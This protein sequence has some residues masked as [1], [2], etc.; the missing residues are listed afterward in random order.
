MTSC[1]SF[2]CPFLPLFNNLSQ[3]LF[4]IAREQQP[5]V[6]FFDE[7]DA[8]MSVRKVHCTNNLSLND[9][10]RYYLQSL[11]VILL[12]MIA[13]VLPQQVSLFDPSIFE[14]VT[15]SVI[16]ILSLVLNS[17]LLSLYRKTSTK[18]HVG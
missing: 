8:L 4:E 13:T 1:H 12:S 15:V 14:T 16:Y 7:I 5:S 17:C 2:S 10:Y 3:A 9:S 18:H 6:I 11:R